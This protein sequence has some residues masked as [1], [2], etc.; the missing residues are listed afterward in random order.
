LYT[1]EQMQEFKNWAIEG[2]LENI[3]NEQI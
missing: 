3:I 1:K 2:G